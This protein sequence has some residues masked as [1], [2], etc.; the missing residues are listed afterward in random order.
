MLHSS[1]WTNPNTSEEKARGK[2][3]RN[4]ENVRNYN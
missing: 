1:V 3:K 2:S 4:T